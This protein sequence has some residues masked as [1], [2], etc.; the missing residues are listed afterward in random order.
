MNLF[1]ITAVIYQACA[2]KATKELEVNV[3]DLCLMR[4]A[5]N[6]FFSIIILNI[7]K[8]NIFK[9]VPKE[10]RK[11][12]FYRCCFGLLGFTTM[13]YS[14]ELIPIFIMQIIYNTSP[15]W[16]S[17]LAHLYLGEKVTNLEKACIFGSFLGVIFIGLSKA[18]VFKVGDVEEE[19]Q[20]DVTIQ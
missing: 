19:K 1:A 15:F 13:V 16:T 17:I 5:I 6:L 9:D 2:K 8:K 20:D 11:T 18:G 7:A 3:L 12:L 14:V 10:H 4:T